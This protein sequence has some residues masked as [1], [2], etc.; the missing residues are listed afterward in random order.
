MGREIKFR[1]WVNDIY[2]AIQGKPDLE[3][4]ESFMFHYG[5]ENNL[6]QFTG[7]KDKNEKEIYEGDIITFTRNVGNWQIGTSRPFISTHQVVW[8]EEISAF[9]LKD[10]SGYIK[11]RRLNGKYIYKV[12][13]NIH[14]NPELL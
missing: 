12:I 13:G 7:L 9:V 14:E 4:L 5:T 1:A 8:E 10:N 6:M 2:M 3:T 11:F